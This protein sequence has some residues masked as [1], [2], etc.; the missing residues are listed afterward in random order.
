MGESPSATVLHSR[1]GWIADVDVRAIS[2]SGWAGVNSCTPCAFLPSMK[3]FALV[4]GVAG[5]AALAVS[6]Q[7]RGQGV[8]VGSPAP[9]F[10]LKALH[11]EDVFRLE[12]NFG[13]RPTVLIF[14]SYT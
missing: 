11:S 4:L 13:K 1:G 9:A 6:A 12:D 2:R 8:P 10:A 5:V 7:R 3:W 14:G